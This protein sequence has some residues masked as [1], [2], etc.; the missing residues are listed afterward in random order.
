MYYVPSHLWSSRHPRE[1][2]EYTQVRDI[3][4]DNKGTRQCKRET[5]WKGGNECALL[6]AIPPSSHGGGGGWKKGSFVVMNDTKIYYVMRG[7][8]KE[9][10]T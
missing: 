6:L 9:K 7:R 4:F 2:S 1:E 8:R 3:G 10:L 5:I